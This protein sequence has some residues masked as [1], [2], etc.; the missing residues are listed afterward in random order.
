MAFDKNEIIEDCKRQLAK[1][2]KKTTAFEIRNYKRPD[3]MHRLVK[4]LGY[5][6]DCDDSEG[7]KMVFDYAEHGEYINLEIEIDE[8]MNIVGGKIKKQN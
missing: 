6:F 5:A 3:L 8:G 7:Q 2:Q 4:D 1:K